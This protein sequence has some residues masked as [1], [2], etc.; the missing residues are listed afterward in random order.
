MASRTYQ[1]EPLDVLLAA[2]PSLPRPVLARLVQQAI[3]RLDALDPDPEL[4]DDDPAEDNGDAE[5]VPAYH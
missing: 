2:I 5:E 4:E 3:D 1:A